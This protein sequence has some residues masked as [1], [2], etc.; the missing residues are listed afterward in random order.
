MSRSFRLGIFVLSTLTILSVSVFLIGRQA[1]RFG[2]TYRVR[3]EFDNVGGL[4]EGADVRVGGIRKG[5]VRSI[6]L[7]KSSDGKVTVIVDL[8]KETQSIVKHDSVA[9]I[10]SEGLLGDKYVE[11]SF[12]SVDAEWL[13]DGDEIESKPPFDI[14]DLFDK[15][16]QVLDTSQGALENIEGAAD[17]LHL[18]TGKINA[19]KGTLGK[20]V[21]DTT[22]YQQAAQGV[23]AVHEDADALKHNFFL[24]G[25]F[26]DRGYT[27]PA[28][29]KNNAISQLP[30]QQPVKRFLFDAKKLFD[31]PDAAKLQNQRFLKEAGQYLQ[32]ESFGMVVITAGTGRTGDSDKARA[33]SEAR[34]YVVRKYL[35]E[36][37]PLDDKRVKTL[38]LGKNVNGAEDGTV[39]ILVY[40]NAPAAV[41]LPP[42]KTN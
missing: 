17:N 6:L 37:F 33:L 25:F 23:A 38:G 19:G 1:S 7:P 4:S 3:S 13:K 11:I 2:G 31:K 15:A 40:S 41:K 35:V 16:G 36:T 10:Q 14:S 26:K 34:S 39:E 28:E 24:R 9:A 12:G 20:L 32:S 30:T 22:L 29:I 42:R 8:Q 27:D 5:T 18:I 21:N